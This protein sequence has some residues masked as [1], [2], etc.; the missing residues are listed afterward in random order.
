MAVSR[1]HVNKARG[2]II[3]CLAKQER[4]YV[5]FAL[6]AA[7]TPTPNQVL[8]QTTPNIATKHRDLKIR[9]NEHTSHVDMQAY[10]QTQQHW[11]DHIHKH[12]NAPLR[13]LHTYD[14]VHSL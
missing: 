14:S 10:E 5:T 12:T 11:H 3:I 8:T 7:R 9:T 13:T 6:S 1:H 2:I 4:S